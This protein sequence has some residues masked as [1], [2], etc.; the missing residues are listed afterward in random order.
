MIVGNSPLS[1][2]GISYNLAA[3]S[4]ISLPTGS[5]ATLAAAISFS[6]VE[7]S[8]LSWRVTLLP[9]GESAFLPAPALL[10][11]LAMLHPL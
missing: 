6:L 11:P 3:T 10:P 7:G 8:T 2:P 5:S 4:S 9:S 1:S